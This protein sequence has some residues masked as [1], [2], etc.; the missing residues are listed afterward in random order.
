M[1]QIIIFMIHFAFGK[2]KTIYMQAQ[3]LI[4]L[5]ED[6]AV[7]WIEGK[8]RTCVKSLKWIITTMKI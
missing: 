5:I 6:G 8:A 4:K 7:R 2:S 3:P 1:H